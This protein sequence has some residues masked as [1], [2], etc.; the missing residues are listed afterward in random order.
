MAT[1]RVQASEGTGNC[2]FSDCLTRTEERMLV[3]KGFWL[4]NRNNLSNRLRYSATVSTPR[5][6]SSILESP[7]CCRC[8]KLL[9]VQRS[10]GHPPRMI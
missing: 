5:S 1:K 3:L 8:A 2:R 10:P 4:S 9:S 6:L 7:V